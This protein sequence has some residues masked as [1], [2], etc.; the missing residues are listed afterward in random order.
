MKHRRKPVGR[1]HIAAAMSIALAALGIGASSA[2]AA[3]D[4]YVNGWLNG[5]VTAPWHTLTQASARSVSGGLVCTT[6][7][8]RD[9][10]TS[11]GA[12]ASAVNG[13]A[14]QPYCGCRLRMGMVSTGSP[15]NVRARVTF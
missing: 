8:N 10:S 3:Y 7:I 14:V 12:C 6:A 9:G 2:T 4:E 13:L 5:T 1:Q 15:V 11:G